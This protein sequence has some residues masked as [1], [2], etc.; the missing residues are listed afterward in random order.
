MYVEN[1]IKKG[2]KHKLKNFKD[3]GHMGAIVTDLM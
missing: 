1:V 3:R 2:L